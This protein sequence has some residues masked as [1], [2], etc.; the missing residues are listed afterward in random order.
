[1][2]DWLSDL[3]WLIPQMVLG[4]CLFACLPAWRVGIAI[5]LVTML[6]IKVTSPL[7]HNISGTSK[8]GATAVIIAAV[9]A[10]KAACL[11]AY[12]AIYLLAAGLHCILTSH[13]STIH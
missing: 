12:M 9:F 5:G 7:T 1:M 3:R 2:S 6:Q 4:R 11:P 13:M 10:V 8:V